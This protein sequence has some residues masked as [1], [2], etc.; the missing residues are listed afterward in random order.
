MT[1][2]AFLLFD[3]FSNMVLSCLL[4][5]LR[6]VRDQAGVDIRWRVMTPGGRPVRSS[7]GLMISPDPPEAAAAGTA[8]GGFDL[9]VVV[10]GYG[11]RDHAAGPGVRQVLALARRARIVLGADAGPWILAAAGLLAE[12]RATLHWSLLPD[13]A[14]TFPEVRVESGRHVMEGRVW[15]C[16]G[17][18]SALD[19]ILAFIAQRFG[20]ANAFIAS[21]MFLHDADPQQPERPPQPG[22]GAARLAGK[23]TAR[24]R[25]VVTLMAQTI[26]TPLPLPRLAQRCGLSPGTLD[27][28]FRAELGMAP[29][30]YYQLLRL[31]HARELAQGSTF[32]LREIALRCGY[33]DA[34]ALSKAFRRVH[35]H[36]VRQSPGARR[37]EPG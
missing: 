18:S 32:D 31:S 20:Q 27:R 28:L 17:A 16:G 34:A 6:A 13:F 35:G 11:Y 7:S 8:G 4:E 12:Q 5:P 37:R 19:L 33:S 21:A 14:E 2:I 29:G 23:G 24:L 3:G 1:R 22:A 10:A 26:E 15:S 25:Q 36:S 30:R 9:L